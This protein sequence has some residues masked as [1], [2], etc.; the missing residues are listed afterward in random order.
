MNE[1][2]YVVIRAK[3]KRNGNI[4]VLQQVLHGKV[5]GSGRSRIRVRRV[6]GSGQVEIWGPKDEIERAFDTELV[7]EKHVDDK[8]TTGTHYSWKWRVARSPQI[9]RD[10]GKHVDDVGIDASEKHGP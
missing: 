7:W 4:G 8:R 6:G 9:T 2:Q 5:R 3:L 1:P 10:I